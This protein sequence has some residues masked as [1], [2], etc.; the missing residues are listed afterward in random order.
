VTDELAKLGSSQGMVPPGVF[1][2]ELHEPSINK[3]I[4]KSNKTVESIDGTAAPADDKSNSSDIMMVDSDWRT[5]FMIYLKT[6]GFPEDKDE[7]E[8]L[9]QWAVHYTLVGEKLFR[10]SANG[11]YAMH[12]HGRKGLL[13]FPSTSNFVNTPI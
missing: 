12:P 10:R 5:P 1:M 2:Q 7:R 6:G 8:R 13:M 3:A 4:S 9:R 11:V